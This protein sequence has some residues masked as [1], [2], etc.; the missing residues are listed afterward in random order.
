MRR[1]QIARLLFLGPLAV[2]LAAVWLHNR[3][4]PEPNYGGRRLSKWASL[5]GLTTPEEKVRERAVK[6][7][8]TNAMPFLVKWAAYKPTPFMRRILDAA[9]DL[10]VALRPSI[11]YAAEERA[12]FSR[13]ILG[14][15]A[16]DDILVTYALNTAS[17]AIPS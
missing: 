10:P 8:G 5:A 4:D 12:F 2:V 9:L 14:D 11:L 13:R 3:S 15:L 7:M 6:A 17:T 1:S 16:R